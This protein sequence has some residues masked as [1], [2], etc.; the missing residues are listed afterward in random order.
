M[1]QTAAQQCCAVYVVL[2]R[3]SGVTMHTGVNATMHNT[4]TYRVRLLTPPLDAL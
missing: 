4:V 3:V 2:C 1:A